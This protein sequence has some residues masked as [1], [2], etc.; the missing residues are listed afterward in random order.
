MAALR[1]CTVSYRDSEGVTHTVDVSAASLYEAAVLG[2]KAFE[3]TGWADHPVG[4]LD[5]IVKSPAVRHQVPVVRVKNW[6]RS[7]GSPRDV[8]LKS[9]LRALLGWND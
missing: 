4:E 2:L 1:S 3:D 8:A 7:A 5:V 9:R 6:L